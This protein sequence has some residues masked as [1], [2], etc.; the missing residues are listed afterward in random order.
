[1]THITPW[2]ACCARALQTHFCTPD[3]EELE[4]L[5]LNHRANDLCPEPSSASLRSTQG[6][7]VPSQCTSRRVSALGSP[8]PA[9]KHVGNAR[10][11]GRSLVW[12]E[13][14]Q[15]TSLAV[16]CWAASCVRHRRGWPTV[17]CR[18]ISRSVE[19]LY[20]KAEHGLRILKSFRTRLGAHRADTRSFPSTSRASH[21]AA[22][23][24]RAQVAVTRVQFTTSSSN[25]R[26][27]LR[28]RSGWWS[29][30]AE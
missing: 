5:P 12:P 18:S 14:Q 29:T 27:V 13:G 20:R 25:G 23:P 24:G 19:W 28:A 9:P 22:N 8:A 17:T 1:M 15:R 11:Q 16:P 26:H 21:A 2:V 6:S 7:L 4:T 30:P 10:G 3:L